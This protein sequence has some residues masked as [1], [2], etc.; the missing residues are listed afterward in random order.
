MVG[1]S[2]PVQRSHHSI[3]GERCRVGF[4]HAPNGVTPLLHI[5]AWHIVGIVEGGDDEDQPGENGEEFVGPDCLDWMGL[6]SRERVD[7]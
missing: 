2:I 1:W 5:I 6:A 4:V 7:C 3:L